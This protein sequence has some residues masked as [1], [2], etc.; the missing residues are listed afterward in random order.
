MR[1]D[2][3]G[4]AIATVALLGF[5]V[6][7]ITTVMT[8][9]GTRQLRNTSSDAQWEQSLHVAEAGLDDIIVKVEADQTFSTG[10]FVPGFDDG[11]AERAWAIAIAD[12]LDSADLLSTPE[13]EYATIV[14]L[15]EQSIYSVGFAP[16]RESVERRV[17]VVRISYTR[18]PGVVPWKAERAFLTGGNLYVTGNP[19]AFEA[20]SN[21]H[22]N[23]HATISGSPTLQDACFSAAAGATISGNLNDHAA[24]P[25]PGGQEAVFIP[26]IEPRD[27]WHLSEFDLCPDGAV[28][29]GPRHPMGDST[30]GEPCTGTMLEVDAAAS[31]YLGWGFTGIDAFGAAQWRYGTN[32]ENHGAYYVYHGS[33]TIP[34]GPGTSTNPWRL[35]LVVEPVGDCPAHVGGDIVLTGAAVVTPYDTAGT[36]MVAGRDVIWDGNGRLK[37]PGI[38]AAVEQIALVGNPQIQGSFVA[39]DACDSP[40]DSLDASEVAGNPKFELLGPLETIWGYED[41]EGA[42]EVVG[43]DEL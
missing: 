16:N 25:D 42:V 18:V 9:R 13:G 21:V 22:A 24:C 40:D 14:P 43:W 4:V 27:F 37:E 29:A 15:N 2:E 23:G 10:E 12:G 17:R 36:F 7:M 41:S 19:T 32:V 35:S 28:R 26:D 33:A 6:V 5:A 30:S 34:S 31:P 1:A 8:L 39:E 3:R 38:I 11:D 20:R